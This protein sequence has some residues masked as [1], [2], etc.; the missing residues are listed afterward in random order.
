MKR[1]RF[2]YLFSIYLIVCLIVNFQNEVFSHFFQDKIWAHRVNS[3][4]KLKEVNSKFGG[5]E[6]DV[7]FHSSTNVF[8]INHP[9]SKSINLSLKKYLSSEKLNERNIFWLDFKNLTEDNKIDACLKLDSLCYE[10]KLNRDQF[11]IESKKPQYL[12]SFYEKGYKTSFYLPE[13]LVSLDE[14]ML[15]EEITD[16]QR[17]ISE[18]KTT[19]LSTDKRDYRIIKEYFPE[20]KYLIWTFYF[21]NK[22][23]INPYHILYG[24]N[25]I[26]HKCKIFPDD[27]VIAVLFKYE[28]REGNR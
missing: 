5:I 7:V 16:I 11:I 9:P 28:A 22:K 20:H 13:N 6:L 10:F 21:F 3:I 23:T 18:N 8:D 26:R 12:N 2:I 14:K 25:N 4:E 19:Y 17:I 15:K 1:K 27:N 24:I